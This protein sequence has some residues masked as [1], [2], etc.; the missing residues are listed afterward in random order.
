MV[1][2]SYRLTWNT[3][4]EEKIHNYPTPDETMG[5]GAWKYTDWETKFN[6]VPL[7]TYSGTKQI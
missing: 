7:E 4:E 1:K 6:E 2:R 3:G 5:Y